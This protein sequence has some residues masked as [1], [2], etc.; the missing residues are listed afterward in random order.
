MKGKNFHENK[1][2]STQQRNPMAEKLSD[3]SLKQRVVQPKK[4]KGAYKRNKG[5]AND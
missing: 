2:K 4:G 5:K 3:G 1:K